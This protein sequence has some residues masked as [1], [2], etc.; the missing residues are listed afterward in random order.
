MLLNIQI[1]NGVCNEGKTVKWKT[2]KTGWV[3]K[4][5]TKSATR[6][7]K[8]VTLVAVPYQWAEKRT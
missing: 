5:V 8:I 4:T 7:H 3:A 2:K 1:T 6:P